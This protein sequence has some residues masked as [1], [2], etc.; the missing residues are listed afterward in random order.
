MDRDSKTYSNSDASDLD[1]S[2]YRESLASDDASNPHAPPHLYRQRK[3]NYWLDDNQREYDSWGSWSVDN[4]SIAISD[5][6]DNQDD[7]EG[8]NG[9][10]SQ[11]TSV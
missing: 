10:G 4:S 2:S 3:M 6:G 8:S 11:G 9:E 1:E 5:N 7:Q